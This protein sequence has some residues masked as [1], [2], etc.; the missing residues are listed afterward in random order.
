MLSLL[1]EL[2]AV[3]RR[4][5]RLPGTGKALVDEAAISEIIR[6]LRST[7]PDETRLGQRIGVERERILADAR[8]QARRILEDAR[9]KLDA[10]VDNEAAVKAARERAR[11][12]QNQAERQAARLRSD[13]DDYVIGQLA[14]LEHRILRIM[15]EVRAGQRVLARNEVEQSESTRQS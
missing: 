13:A 6:K 12:I 5:M 7:I 3:L 10:R 8:D 4:A 9:A 14:G 2:E 11:E 15:Q 1:D